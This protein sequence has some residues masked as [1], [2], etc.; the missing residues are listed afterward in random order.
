MLSTS[1]S[2]VTMPNESTPQRHTFTNPLAG[3][4]L[5]DPFVLRHRGEFYLYGT[6][7]GA[8]LPDGRVVPVFRSRNLID[9]EPLGGAL[10]PH[11][12][13]AEH[14]APE[15]LAWN[16]RYYMV[17]SFGDVVEHGH[18]LWVAVADHPAGPFELRSRVSGQDER[19][20]ID[21]AW[22]LDDD[23]KLYL[24]RCVDFIQEDDLPHGTGIVVQPMCDPLTPAGPAST[25]LR[26]SASWHLFERERTMPLYESRRFAE[27]TTIEGPAPVRRGERYYCGYSGGNYTGAYGTGEAVAQAPLGPYH[28]LRGLEGPI[29]GGVP[30][31]IEGP[32]HFSVVQPDLI[33]DWIALHGRSPHEA[34]RRVWLCPASWGTAGVAIGEL[35]DQPQPAPSLPTERFFFGGT[36]AMATPGWS[37]ERGDW[38]S[39][40]DGLWHAAE[41]EGLIWRDGLK[42]TGDW[43][44][45]VYVRFPGHERSRG[46]VVLDSVNRCSVVVEQQPGRAVYQDYHGR[47]ATMALPCLGDESFNLHAFHPIVLRSQSGRV[48]ARLDQVVLFSWAGLTPGCWRLGFVAEGHVVF[49]AVSISLAGL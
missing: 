13:T 11:E 30:G 18:A 26:A 14:W 28:D 12:P 16:G 41:K 23:G 32:G 9:W 1:K 47:M 33:H 15:V 27:W 3:I 44:V 17:V 39:D 25:V 45:E 42:L 43:A 21:G 31:L 4:T 49:D 48:E 37:I 38:R 7:D 35:S 36:A 24:F 20:S 5:G 19:F 6:N 10:V 2:S 40:L 29:F 34:V 8:P 46:G 22:L